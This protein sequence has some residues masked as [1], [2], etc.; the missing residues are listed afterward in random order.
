MKIFK[1]LVLTILI[2]CF[3]GIAFA[4]VPT[5]S[6]DELR[7]GMRGYAKTV[8]KGTTIE[9][10][11]VEVLGVTGSN[12]TGQNILIKASGPVI[13]RSGGIA[14]G[15]SGSP[16][17]INGRLAGAVA[18]GKAF[19]DPNYCF[20][21]PIE[22]MLKLFD[23]VNPR[24][25]SFVPKNTPLMVSGFSQ[26]GLNYLNDKLSS[27]DLKAYSVPSGQVNLENVDLEPGS[28]LGVQ[29]VRGDVQIGAIGTVTW[30]DEKGNLLA[31][32]HPF[33]QRGNADYFLTNAWIFASVPNMESAFKVGTLGKLLGRV[34]QDRSVGIGAELNKFPKIIPMFVSVTD[35]DRGTHLN[36]SAQLVTDE[37]LVPKL[38]DSV[39]FNTISKA[40]DRNGG[41]TSRINFKVTARG[42]ESGEIELKRENMMFDNA[43][44]AKATDA[45]LAFACE[46]LAKN[47]FEKVDIFD[48]NVNVEMTTNYEVAEI[49]GAKMPNKIYKP[50]ELVPISVEF[51]PYRSKNFSKTVEFKVPQKQ[52]EGKVKLVIRGGSSYGWLQTLLKRQAAA[53]GSAPTIEKKKELKAF[54]KDFNEADSNNQIIVDILPNA[55][56]RSKE[57]LNTYKTQVNTSDTDENKDNSQEG[58]KENKT[59][60]P[61]AMTSLNSMLKGS[62][63]KQVFPMDFVIDG[64]VEMN[65]KVGSK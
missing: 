52:K 34:S 27:L 42:R 7:P 59:L 64:E 1:F 13:E 19:S 47:K 2:V 32:G 44:I 24:P 10:F 23:E 50:G 49:I 31:F 37:D 11:D 46:M 36:T 58:E 30:L 55:N 63:D 33:L 43:Q 5:I 17:Y 65:L 25:S 51:K 53:G 3:N 4:S 16:V 54:L 60:N 8:I 21:T 57:M 15:M 29:L 18:F 12:T 61:G 6:A 41:G 56:S 26:E 40:I 28:S 14:Q 35:K 20:L 38:V 9:T 45:E 22:D 48:I 39:C 62:K